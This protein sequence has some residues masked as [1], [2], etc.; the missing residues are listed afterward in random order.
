MKTPLPQQSPFSTVEEGSPWS[1]QGRTAI[2]KMEQYVNISDCIN[3]EIDEVEDSSLGPEYS[4]VDVKHILRNER[5]NGHLVASK[6]RWDDCQRQRKSQEEKAWKESQGLGEEDKRKWCAA[7]EDAAKKML[8]YLD[9]SED[10]ES[11]L[12]RIEGTIGTGGR[13][14]CFYRADCQ[15]GK[16]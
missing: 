2:E 6:W 16:E 4:D 7:F 12:E 11:W 14:R 9:D 5:K 10:F 8:K 3:L 13:S 1:A 15:T